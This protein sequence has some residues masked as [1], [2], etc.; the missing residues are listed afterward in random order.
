MDYLTSILLKD[1]GKIESG[2][3]C[4]HQKVFEKNSHKAEITL[5][6]SPRNVISGLRYIRFAL[7]PVGVVLLSEGF[8][9]SLRNVISGIRYSL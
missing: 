9:N 8:E 4:R 3:F 6:N 1:T 7:I 2:D 5:K